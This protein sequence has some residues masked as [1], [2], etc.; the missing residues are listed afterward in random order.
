MT[1]PIIRNP[2]ITLPALVEGLADRFG[3]GV[4]LASEG[5][6]LTYREL[7]K[8]SNIYALWAMRQ[9]I[10]SGDVVC[11]VMP[12]CPEYIA[13]WLGI[14]RVGG[15]VALINT[16]LIGQSLAHSLN[17]VL[18]KHIIVDAELAEAVAAVRPQLTP[19]VRYW[20]RGDGCDGFVRID[21]EVDDNPSDQ[22]DVPADFRSPSIR[23][24]ALYIF[25]SGTTGLP[26]AARVSHFRLMQWSHWFA[27]MMDTRSSDRM[28]NCLPMY[29]SVG[30]VVAIGAMLVSGGTV[31][32]RRR[33]SAKRFWEDVVE[34]RCTIF[35]YIGE[36]CRYL[37]NSPP[38]RWEV[39]H[40]LRLCCGNGL[41]ADIWEKFK[42]RFE[43][44][45]ILEFYA[46]TE[47]NF[48]LYNCEG[49]P[50][51]IGRIPS[52]LAHRFPV[53]LIKVDPETAEPIRNEK[54]LCLRCTA[55]EVGEAIGKIPDAHASE[56]SRFE[57]Y[58]DKGASE[59]KVL[60]NVFED[61]DAWY[62]TGDLMRKDEKGYFYF[63]DRVGDTFRWKGENVS[64]AEVAE[65]ILRCHGVDDA[66]VYGVTVPGTE[67]RA[68]MAAI[69]AGNEFDLAAFG[70]HVTEYLPEYARP[71][72][73]RIRSEI[74]ITETFKPKKRDLANE[75]F[76]PVTITD[77]VYFYDR[78]RADFVKL[79]AALYDRILSLNVRL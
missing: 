57:G 32:L 74:A 55:N 35:Q 73:L 66:V 2:E 46:A 33:F 23:D 72:F 30:G 62:R 54:G 63:V 78:T 69:V 45:W 56:G 36:L 53:A 68:G 19:G 25:T 65:T 47:S 52:F 27:G 21:H 20:V 24:C 59:R 1:A 38:G 64:T 71:L 49:K 41:R 15:V 79:D 70:S 39:G 3:A 50:G 48:S 17:I 67:G 4:A 5:Q 51:A 29:H 9:G 37:V 22:L 76:N 6:S 60:R 10:G 26:K 77:E 61:G 58:T 16:N 40:Q 8:R 34:S 44:P 75:G 31:V 14:T 13:I 11:L 7:A 18:P 42:R 28:Y 43:I 12:N